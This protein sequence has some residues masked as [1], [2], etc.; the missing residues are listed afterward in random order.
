MNIYLKS[1]VQNLDCEIKRLTDIRQELLNGAEFSETPLQL[2]G[3]LVQTPGRDVPGATTPAATK[4]RKQKRGGQRE[5]PK[6]QRPSSKEQPT[7][8]KSTPALA[9]A[10]KVSTVAGAMKREIAGWGNR[11][12][13]AEELRAACDAK[14]GDED[15]WKNASSS[16][17]SGNLSYWSSKGRLDKTDKGYK[18]ADAAF[19]EDTQY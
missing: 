13:T 15:W 1:A 16:A 5:V 12:F 17:V 11:E 4:T 9:T 10:D 2:P 8:R 3:A 14:Y 7:E 18:S 19:F 6:S